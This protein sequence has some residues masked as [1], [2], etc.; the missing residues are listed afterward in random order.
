MLGFVN[1]EV[2]HQS[3]RQLAPVNVTIRLLGKGIAN[4]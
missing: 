4:S 1:A 2:S 3:T